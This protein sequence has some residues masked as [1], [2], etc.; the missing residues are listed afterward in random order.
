M[1]RF[2]VVLALA[3]AGLALWL[4]WGEETRAG[5]SHVMNELRETGPGLFFVAMALL[6]LAGFPL[7]PFTLAAG[8]VFGP[9]MGGPVVIVCA[10]S[11]VSVNVALSY[12]IAGRALRPVVAR[13]LARF[14]WKL[15]EAPVKSALE[16][17]LLLRVVPGTP[18][19]VQSYLLG[20][21]RVPFGLY[22]AVSVGVPAAYI[23][24]TIL[25]GDALGRGD[26]GRLATA[27]VFCAVAGAGLHFLRK[28]LM[29]RLRE[30]RAATVGVEPPDQRSGL[31]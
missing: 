8:P 14:G 20:L 21:A 16:L 30:R 11:A 28:R 24:A 10:V 29:K 6:P 13:L 19:F 5:A 26:H 2:D 9:R 25:A 7:A 17:T 12:W 1:G 23:A 15:P 4:L 22:M 31:Q 18:F 3:L 27:G